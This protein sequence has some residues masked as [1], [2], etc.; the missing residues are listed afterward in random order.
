ML[1]FELRRSDGNRARGILER[2]QQHAPV[3]D[4]DGGPVRIDDAGAGA[5]MLMLAM[6]LLPR[7][8]LLFLV[9]LLF[10]YT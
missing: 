2:C 5:D 7:L 6:L 10:W 1:R 3:Q 4:A 9:P 8:L